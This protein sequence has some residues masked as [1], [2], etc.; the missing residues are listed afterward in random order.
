MVGGKK[1]ARGEKRVIINPPTL[2]TRVAH[3][4]TQPPSIVPH[5]VPIC[6]PTQCVVADGATGKEN[7][8][9]YGGDGEK[10]ARCVAHASTP[11]AREPSN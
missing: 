2:F 8:V 11:H 5:L 3:G 1:K 6:Q 7:R 9:G 10:H 4:Y